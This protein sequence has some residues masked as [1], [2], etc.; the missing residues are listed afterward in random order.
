MIQAICS[1]E[2][3]EAAMMRSPSFSRSRSSTT[4]TNSPAFIAEIVSCILLNVILEGTTAAALYSGADIPSNSIPVD[5]GKKTNRQLEISQLS[6]EFS[7]DEKC[8]ANAMN[9]SSMIEK[10]QH[11]L[12]I[13]N[14]LPRFTQYPPSSPLFIIYPFP[15]FPRY[16]PSAVR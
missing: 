12:N 7:R 5:F 3:V 11:L 15:I 16:Y 10:I 14:L 8:D 2:R 1:V 9:A 4:I 6:L 13:S